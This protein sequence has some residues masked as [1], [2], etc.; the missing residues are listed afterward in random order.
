MEAKKAIILFASALL[1]TST[2]SSAQ[3]SSSVNWPSK[4]VTFVLTQAPGG[5]ND[6]TGR[7][8]AQK[9][10]EIYKQPF[11]VDNRPGHR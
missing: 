5:A 2:I 9:L 11:I 7:A 10:T 1:L 8:L 3:T 4:P 6:I